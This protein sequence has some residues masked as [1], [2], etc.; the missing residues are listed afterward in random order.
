MATFFEN[1]EEPSEIEPL[2]HLQRDMAEDRILM[3]NS[4]F[5]RD[6]F[7]MVKRARQGNKNKS[8]THVKAVTFRSPKESNRFD[9]QDKLIRRNIGSSSKK[10]PSYKKDKDSKMEGVFKNREFLKNH[11]EMF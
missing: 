3:F 7:E 11:R 5:I 6:A 10:R 1:L 2:I 4:E 9:M 8:K